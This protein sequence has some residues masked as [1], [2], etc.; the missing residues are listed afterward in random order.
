MSAH[1]DFIDPENSAPLNPI[2]EHAITTS[3]ESFERACE[4]LANDDA[5]VRAMAGS[6]L[7]RAFTLLNKHTHGSDLQAHLL[8]SAQRNI[9][10]ATRQ[11]DALNNSVERG[12]V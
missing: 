6:L 11:V 9:A 10:E 3:D 8:A 4:R 2:A 7:G 12:L 1:D 5:A